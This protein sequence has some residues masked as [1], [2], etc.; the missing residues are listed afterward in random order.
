MDF[1]RRDSR[2][3]GEV[4]ADGEVERSRRS[5][6]MEHMRERFLSEQ[7]GRFSI[8]LVKMHCLCHAVWHVSRGQKCIVNDSGNFWEE[9]G[10]YGRWQSE[11]TSLAEKGWRGSF[12]ARHVE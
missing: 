1:E 3:R 6:G 8:G 4:D 7:V 12:K 2:E 9:S 10:L 5:E 11:Q